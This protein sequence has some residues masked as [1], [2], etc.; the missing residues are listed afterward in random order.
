MRE[1]SEA[2]AIRILQVPLCACV[3]ACVCVR[4]CVYTGRWS[5]HSEIPFLKKRRGKQQTEEPQEYTR[6]QALLPRLTFVAGTAW[7]VV[8]LPTGLQ[9][10]HVLADR[11]QGKVLL[12]FEVVRKPLIVVHNAQHATA[13]RAHAQRLLLQIPRRQLLFESRLHRNSTRVAVLRLV[14]HVVIA[15]RAHTEMAHTMLGARD[16]E[17]ERGA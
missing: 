2:G 13:H 4:S 6:Q 7:A 16:T 1:Y 8:V 5:F 11:S 15:T 10:R 3:C 17:E 12:A 14:R 9:I